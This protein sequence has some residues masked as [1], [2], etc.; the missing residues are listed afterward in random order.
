MKKYYRSM[1]YCGGL[2]PKTWQRV[3]QYH[4]WNSRPEKGSYC[5]W[6]GREYTDAQEHGYYENGKRVVT[7]SAETR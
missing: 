1:S 5:E 6:C 3:G 2:N 4:N 7:K